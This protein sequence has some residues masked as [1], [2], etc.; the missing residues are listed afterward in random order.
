MVPSVEIQ[1]SS[2]LSGLSAAAVMFIRGIG[3]DDFTIVADPAVGTHLDGVYLGRT[4][5][6]LLELADVERIEVLRGPQG[7]LFGRNS[8]GGAISVVSRKPEAEFGSDLRVTLGQDE[9][10]EL[11]AVVN[12]PLSDTVYSRFS[13]LHRHREGY[14]TATQYDDLFT[15]SD[16]L[17]AARGQISVLPSDSLRLDL[18]ADYTQK[19]ETPAAQT[20]FLSGGPG[21]N[22]TGMGNPVRDH[23]AFNQN[24]GGLPELSSNPELCGSVRRLH[25]M[26]AL[27]H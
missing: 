5:G 8:I 3:Q 14:V 24:L 19:R 13:Y 21:P 12:A 17:D 25:G 4:I 16:G 1:G 27:G 10:Q 22:W 2:N 15:G 7:T 18:A 26:S 20:L 6:S 11:R 9:R 23:L